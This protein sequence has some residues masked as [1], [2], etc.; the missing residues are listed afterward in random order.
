MQANRARLNPAGD[1]NRVAFTLIE[2]LVVIAVIAI[3]AAMLLPGLSRAKLTGQRVACLDNLRQMAIS[4]RIYTD[5]NQG[6]L[7][8]AVAN[9][10]SVDT[11][12]Q[13]GNAGVL[14]CPSTQVP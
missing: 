13:T 6:N 5:D 7:I 11:A 1:L 9:E 3:L 2:L 4:R 10:D 8:L 14:I 12:V